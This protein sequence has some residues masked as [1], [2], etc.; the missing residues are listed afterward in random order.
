MGRN[1]LALLT[2]FGRLTSRFGTRRRSSSGLACC[3]KFALVELTLCYMRQISLNIEHGHTRRRQHGHG[4][5]E[6]APEDTA[7]A[8]CGI[9]EYSKIPQMI[10]QKNRAELMSL[11]PQQLKEERASN[12]G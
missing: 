5:V 2:L 8:R 6:R 12:A 10:A 3:A 9:A 4:E 7:T 11:L 1:S